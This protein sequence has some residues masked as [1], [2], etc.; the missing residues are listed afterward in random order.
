MR[1]QPEALWPLLT[2]AG[3]HL[4]ICGLRGLEDGVDAALTEIARNHGTDWLALRDTMRE[5]GRFHSETY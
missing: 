1:A 5:E 4:Y 3:L 2:Q